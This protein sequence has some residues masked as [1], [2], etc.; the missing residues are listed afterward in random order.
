MCSFGQR[1]TRVPLDPARYYLRGN[2]TFPH[3]GSVRT[4]TPHSLSTRR[5]GSLS[6]MSLCNFRR[7]K[8]VLFPHE[9]VAEYF[10][11]N[12]H[13]GNALRTSN[14]PGD[15][16]ARGYDMGKV[17]LRCTLWCCQKSL[18]ACSSR[19][20]PQCCLHIGVSNATLISSMGIFGLRCECKTGVF[21]AKRTVGSRCREQRCHHN[22]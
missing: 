11:V 7:C 16:F 17:A 20:R 10:H 8:Q 1:V 14:M 12:S 9:H 19:K 22:A 5:T 4:A 13:L 18:R 3:S 15:A 21:S 6:C 2:K